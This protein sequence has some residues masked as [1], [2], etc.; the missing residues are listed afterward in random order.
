M[1]KKVS[2]S[3][4]VSARKKSPTSRPPGGAARRKA[5][6]KP[7]VRHPFKLRLK[8]VKLVLEKGHS[9]R[10][11]SE[12]LGIGRSTLEKWIRGYRAKGEEGLKD[13]VVGAAP[14]KLHPSVKK[15]ITEVKKANPT[16]GVRRVSAALKRFFCVSASPETVRK[17]LKEENLIDPPTKKKP[18]RN[19]QKPRFFERATPNQLWQSD[20]FTFRLAGRQAY[21]IGFLDDYSRYITGLGV[22]RSQTAAHVLEVYRRATAEYNCPKEMLTDNGRQYTNWRGKTRFESEMTKDRVKHI[23][24]SPHHPMTL[25][26]IERFWKTL[27][28]EFLGRAQFS[29]FE[30]TRERLAHWVKYYNH[31]RPHQGIG[32]LCPA[33][34]FYEIAHDL[35]Q[36]VEQGIQENVLEIALRGKPRDPFYMVGRMGQQSVEIRAEKGKVR[37]LVDGEEKDCPK[38]LVYQ[39]EKEAQDEREDQIPAEAAD[40]TRA[41][42]PQAVPGAGEVP[43]GPG[44][45]ERQAQPG[46][47]LPGAGDQLGGAAALAGEGDERYPAG[48][49]TEGG[50]EDG[51]PACA[52]GEAAGAAGEEGREADREAGEDPA[53][54]APAAA[55]V[56]IAETSGRSVPEP[57]REEDGVGGIESVVDREPAQGIEEP[58]EPL[59]GCGGADGG[60]R[61]SSSNVAARP[62]SDP[63]GENCPRRSAPDERSRG[64]AYPGY[65]PADA[66]GPLVPEGDTVAAGVH[67]EE[68]EAD[69]TEETRDPSGERPPARG[70]DPRCAIRANDGRGG[71]PADGRLPADVLQ[72]GAACAGGT[73]GRAGGAPAG[74]TTRRTGPGEGV[75]PAAAGAVAGGDPDPESPDGYPAGEGGGDETDEPEE[76]WPAGGEKIGTASWGRW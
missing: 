56:P 71:G 44:G 32:S 31:R 16:F 18:K 21:V 8:A 47:D 12:E 30:D 76:S 66:S 67:S 23:K 60:D 61:V 2:R 36:A 74:E 6:R 1:K 33:D 54:P 34:R 14:A 58:S 13:G 5:A 55:V 15:K 37:M 17:T 72:V 24:S 70:G 41:Q 62:V 75:P 73:G 28:T 57:S 46:G 43:G 40:E 11:V 49:G 38:E 64:E 26:K 3:R 45:L 63:V 39:I 51:A 19:P 29:S 69:D 4:K 22:Y 65:P 9:G 50:E 48:S 10:L 20:I 53:V 7:R 59:N 42:A 52:G 35:R 25:G 68:V 27:F